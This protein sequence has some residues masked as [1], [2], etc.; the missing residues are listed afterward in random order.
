MGTFESNY[1]K[2]LPG[3]RVESGLQEE[4]LKSLLKNF[5]F[6][7]TSLAEA[8]KEKKQKTVVVWVTIRDGKTC[9]SVKAD[10]MIESIFALKVS[11]NCTGSYDETWSVYYDIIFVQIN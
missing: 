8:K 11:S 6:L 4:T 2:I 5:P 9:R 10:D 3:L 7:A 1:P